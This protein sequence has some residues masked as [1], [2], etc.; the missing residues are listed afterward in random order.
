MSARCRSEWRNILLE[1]IIRL[2]PADTELQ[3]S[4]FQTKNTLENL[5]FVRGREGGRSFILKLQDHLIP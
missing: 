4:R 1:G 3:S 5:M 2:E